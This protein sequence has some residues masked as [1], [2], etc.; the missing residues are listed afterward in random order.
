VQPHVLV[1]G[2]DYQPAE[3]IGRELVE[4]GGGRVVI[5]PLTPQRSTTSLVERIRGAGTAR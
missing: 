2:G 4:A 3:V 1:K 5:V